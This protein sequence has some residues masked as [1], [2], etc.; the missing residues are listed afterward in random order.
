MLRDKLTDQ[1]KQAMKAKDVLRLSALRYLMSLVKNKEIDKKSELTDEEVMGLVKTEVKKRREAVEQFKKGGRDDL[2]AEEE[3][4]IKVLEEF[5]PEQM[6]REEIEKVVEKVRGDVDDFG[7]V[8]GKVMNEVKGKADGKLVSE[9]V[10]NK[11]G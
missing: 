8:M 11:L 4:K 7:Q 10:K 2:V 9:V 6:S 5:L 3:E 1:M